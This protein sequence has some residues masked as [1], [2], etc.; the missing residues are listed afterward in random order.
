MHNNY[1]D[2]YEIKKAPPAV[3]PTGGGLELAYDPN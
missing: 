2:Y 1:Q 3:G